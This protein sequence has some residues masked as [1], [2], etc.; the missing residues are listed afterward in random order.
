MRPLVPA[1][2]VRYSDRQWLGNASFRS[3]TGDPLPSRV[4]KDDA[5]VI[6]TI[7]SPLGLSGFA[8]EITLQ[9]GISVIDDSKADTS[10]F[11]AAGGSSVTAAAPTAAAPAVLPVPTP[12]ASVLSLVGGGA[13]AAST[14]P[15]SKGAFGNPG[16]CDVGISYNGSLEGL[17]NLLSSTCNISWE[18]KNG[19]VR[20]YFG[21]IRTFTLAALPSNNNFNAGI[22]ADNSAGVLS[23]S[24]TTQ[25]QSDLWKEISSG[26]QGV[27]GGQGLVQLSPAL[28]TITVMAGPTAMG[29]AEKYIEEANRRLTRQV[30]VN[31]KLIQ[32]RLRQEDT[33]GIGL[34]VL[35]RNALGSQ[36]IRYVSPGTTTAQGT[37]SATIV[38]NSTAVMTALS[39]MGDLKL[40]TDTSVTTISGQAAPINVGRRRDYVSK[41]ETTIS[42][43]ST[44]TSVSTDKL[45]TGFNMS[46]LPRV[47]D[48]GRIVMQY[49]IGLSDGD[50][51]TLFDNGND[52]FIQGV[53]IQQLGF[54]QQVMMR[55]G[56][57][58]VLAGYNQSLLKK[59]D[60]GVPGLSALLG[61][62]E[63]ATDQR[64]AVVIVISPSMVQ[65]YHGAAR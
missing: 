5:I 19:A 57:A 3:R 61:G 25:L 43:T 52:V 56:E 10:L 2:L 8:E 36:G 20:F 60:K 13:S 38:Q 15:A 63:Q 46:V 24:T 39:E 42:Q 33:V 58:L 1:G 7:G 49:G 4:M 41:I 37:L 32:L 47:L 14:T 51:V 18:Y 35:F 50:P 45:I 12:P 55:S 26:L 65:S 40:D 11:P 9:T 34:D 6:N 27:L 59:T 30:S 64:Q 29:R 16:V 31:V 22:A 17:L 53:D 54:L 62:S 48:D 21:E 23:T 28:G 44:T